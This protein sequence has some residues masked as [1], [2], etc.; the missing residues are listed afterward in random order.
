MFF[1]DIV[2]SIIH[3]ALTIFQWHLCTF[4]LAFSSRQDADK[5]DIIEPDIQREGCTATVQSSHYLAHAKECLSFEDGGD[6]LLPQESTCTGTNDCPLPGES[7]GGST[8]LSTCRE[9]DAMHSNNEVSNKLSMLKEKAHLSNE[10][11]EAFVYKC[12]DGS[13]KRANDAFDEDGCLSTI[14][15]IMG[16][17][18]QAPIKFIKIRDPGEP[19]AIG[20]F[21]CKGPKYGEK[22]P[23]S[24]QV[25][26]ALDAGGQ[27]KQFFQDIIETVL[28]G[29]SMKLFE[30]SSGKV[31]PVSSSM[32]LMFKTL[33]IFGRIVTH[34]IVEGGQAFPFLSP[35]AHWYLI[36][37][38]VKT[39]MHH[40]T[41]L[42]Q[43]L[44]ELNMCLIR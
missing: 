23:I 1:S 7:S 36:T 20:L 30:G 19:F 18:L 31:A 44:Q 43:F 29:S 10:D 4:F 34:P 25:E 38:C 8:A 14:I 41:I 37:E 9:T 12:C 2:N 32:T 35:T 33:K 13:W 39:A 16:C 15:A 40:A 27:K 5:Q 28:A 22:R 6:L 17:K 3:R 26:V 21:N 42:M 24:V 11:C